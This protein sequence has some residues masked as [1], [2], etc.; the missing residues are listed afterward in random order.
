MGKSKRKFNIKGRQVVDD[1]EVRKRNAECD[2]PVEFAEDTTYKTTTS[3][4]SNAL[5]IPSKRQKMNVK[6]KEAQNVPKKLTKKQRK[7]LQRIVN[8][9]IKKANRAELLEALAK[10]QA[11]SRELAL[12]SSAAHMGQKITKRQADE[13]QKLLD[14]N[15]VKGSNKRKRRKSEDEEEE[16]EKISSSEDESE[17]EDETEA[18]AKQ[19]AGET[20]K[21]S[22][23]NIDDREKNTSKQGSEINSDQVKSEEKAGNS[24]QAKAPTEKEKEKQDS[25]PAVYVIVERDPD[26]QEARLALPIL[27]EEQE[28][29][30]KIKEHPVVIISGE[31]GSGKTTQVPQFLYEAGYAM[32][33][34]IGITEPRRVAAVTMS[35][36]VAKETSLSQSRFVS[37]QI[38]YEGNVTDDTKIKF[39]TDGVL[40][41][42]IQRDFLLSQY[43]V[44]IID[45]A[46][47]RSV[48][49][50]ILIGLLSRIVPLRHKKNN[51]LKLII[52]SAT[53]RV[54][55][56]TENS[57]LFKITPP[58]I[59]VNA[60]QYP[61][62]VHFNKRTEMVD[63]IN[64]AF[65]K[66][67]KIHR[68]LPPGGILVFVTGQNEV[69]TLCRKLREVYTKKKFLLNKQ[70]D[71]ESKTATEADGGSDKKGAIQT[72]LN[73]K[74]DSEES[75]KAFKK[76]KLP[77][78]N[79]DSY[80]VQPNEEPEADEADLEDDLA[81]E[82]DLKV[83]KDV[84][85]DDDD[86]KLTE[87]IEAASE[88]EMPLF[89]LP[90]FSLLSPQKQALVFGPTPEDSRLCVVA[91]NVAETSLT[92]P[93][94]KY[95]VD[96]GRV[97]KRHY[98]KV[99]G[100]SSFKVSW[101]SKASANQRAGRAGRTE[102]GHCYRLY[103]SAVF[104]N[105]FQTFDPPEITRRPV[106]DLVLQ[107]KDMGIDKVVNF[108]FPSPPDEEALKASERLLLSL[109]ALEQPPKP[110]QFQEQ[111][112]ETFSN[113][114]SPL[115]RA[116]ACFPV[117]PCYAKMIALGQQHECLPYIIALVSALT[118][119]EIFE[120]HFVEGVSEEEKAQHHK[121][122]ERIENNKRLWAGKGASFL[123]GDLMVLLGAVG[124]TEY[125]GNTPS[126]C[127]SH[128]LRFK[129]M[130]EIRK[131]RRLL[132]N[133]VNSV[134][135]DCEVFVDP[136]MK[137][138]SNLQIKMLRQVVLVG[139]AH[140]IARRNPATEENHV[141]G[142]Y[143]SVGIE[144]AVFIH[145]S[146]V[147][148]KDEPEYVVYQEIIETS[149][150]YMK[151]VVAIEPEWLP[152]LL[153]HLCTF[154]KPQAGSELYHTPSGTVRCLRTCTFGR[155]A[156]QISAQEMEYPDCLDKYKLF[157]KYLLEGQVFGKLRKF[158]DLLLSSPSTM[159]KTW[160]KLQPRTQVLLNALLKQQ[161]S[162]KEALSEAWK[163]NDKFLMKEY[164]E[165]LPPE[166][167]STLMLMWPPVDESP[168]HKKSKK[169]KKK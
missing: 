30:E 115:G 133:S 37:Y 159:I 135:P 108:P 163:K 83:T 91:T 3:D 117:S 18:V 44:L 23:S 6:T 95:V 112:K 68:T 67:M 126:F 118:V 157:A 27:A 147:L 76:T 140:H 130:A 139:L 72:Q 153:P 74:E 10:H 52:M 131:L 57:R 111:V 148:F 28:I 114:I 105:D 12:L 64:E 136:E 144:G 93:G 154:S 31:T 168:I 125:A 13:K 79:L 87:S 150:P 78:F 55:D 120:S 128:G 164:C 7:N 48:F 167:H 121:R 132:T 17:S 143:Q 53:L 70:S 65:K 46:H 145:P 73:E 149:K 62:T 66:V 1:S 138:P 84:E 124:A 56:F 50:D 63:Y 129:A 4:D 82:Y 122:H 2:V 45:E 104:G 161:V 15:G 97:K 54:E 146:S 36:R 14:I 51:P 101:T 156:W 35:Q 77:K 71:E 42:E 20:Q 141:K 169:A 32:N 34:K 107:M 11:S 100:I 90:M 26:I 162:S 92:I 152:H 123:L 49:T 59:K 9:K 165:W 113:S 151:G 40:L 69:V 137:P 89:V 86:D 158:S 16:E 119:R 24:Q 155:N 41:K 99:T 80:S 106:D 166:Q 134:D 142:S 75:W 116:M 38:R 96:T 94:I 58:V 43:S 109:G 33:G 110:T 98:D 29:M 127:G 39:M 5:V 88:D 85:S 8:Q 21:D 19:E 103:S 60:R 102:P 47:E 81:D 22:G 61:V 160:A 25:K